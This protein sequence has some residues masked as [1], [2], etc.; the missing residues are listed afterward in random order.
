MAGESE[1]ADRARPRCL[2]FD[3]QR[4]YQGQIVAPH[5]TV[6]SIMRDEADKF[7]PSALEAW[8]QFADRLCV[9][10]DGST[11]RT[12]ELLLT[13]GA[14]VH[15]QDPSMFRGQVTDEW[16]SR[17]KLWH[18]ATRVGTDYVI[19]LDAD[20]VLSCDPRPFLRE[21]HPCFRVFDLW[22]ENEYRED[23]WWVGHQTPWW[24]GAYVPLLPDDFRDQWNERGVHCGHV[25]VNV[26]GQRC[27]MPVECAVLHYGFSSP[28]LRQQ[29]A[30]RYEEIAA[31]LTP[32]ERFHAQTI[33]RP[34]RTKPLPFE[35]TWRLRL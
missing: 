1:I 17:R 35:P 24:S 7:L 33:L 2:Q 25:P 21:A 4:D 5:I 23:A 34:A 6:A 29:K 18:L 26:P 13:A 15:Q 27:N 11:D 9:L 10:D 3:H 30:A 32:Q 20:Q 31:S 12:V 28:E 14:E 16:R 22:S 8:T 19:W